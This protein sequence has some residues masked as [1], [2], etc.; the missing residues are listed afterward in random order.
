MDKEQYYEV[1]GAVFRTVDNGPMEIYF[2]DGKWNKY[3]GDADRVLRLSNPM[4][5]EEVKPFMDVKRGDTAA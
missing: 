3:T 1:E 2:G 4:T 5:L